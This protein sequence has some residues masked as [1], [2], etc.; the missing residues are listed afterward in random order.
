[1]TP[2][3]LIQMICQNLRWRKI[4]IIVGHAS[5]TLSVTKTRYQIV[6]KSPQRNWLLMTQVIPCSSSEVQKAI[7]HNGVK[8]SWQEGNGCCLDSWKW[9][10]GSI[11]IGSYTPA[12]NRG[13]HLTENTLHDFKTVL[14]VE[15]IIASLD[16]TTVV[17]DHCPRHSN[18]WVQSRLVRLLRPI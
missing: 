11:N 2:N 3:S 7:K 12:T 8:G 9:S 14:G 4:L 17:A 5:K 18:C 13:M 16:T 15:D 10:W 1:M 6:M